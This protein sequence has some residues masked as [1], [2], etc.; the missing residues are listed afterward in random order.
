VELVVGD[1]RREV[2]AG[3]RTWDVVQAD[4]ILPQSS[5]SGFLYSVEFLAEVRDALNP[6]G[7]FVQ[8]APTAR[9]A[10]GF[11][12]AFPHVLLI[13]PGSI[14]VGSNQPIAWD[15]DALRARLAAPDF[16]AR[17]RAAGVDPDQ[18]AALF[19]GPVRVW[20][21]ESPRPTLE[22]NTD[23]FPR[24]EFYLNNEIRGALDPG[25]L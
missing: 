1:G 16:V 24:D 19:A 15:P 13:A 10:A 2:L 5:H 14:L 6:G 25:A 8:W 9:V 7:I 22:A 3:G 11:V 18:F 21:P 12:Q 20:G 4:A 23:L 17:A